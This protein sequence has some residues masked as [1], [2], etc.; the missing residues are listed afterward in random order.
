MQLLPIGATVLHHDA[1]PSE[2]IA[3][4]EP[5]RRE[6]Q[7]GMHFRHAFVIEPQIAP[8]ARAHERYHAFDAPP[9][10]PART[11]TLRD[12]LEFDGGKIAVEARLLRL[13]GRRC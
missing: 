8:T 6:D 7:A 11:S 4:P 5:A 9:L 12:E 10:A 2:E 3:D 13:W 1:S